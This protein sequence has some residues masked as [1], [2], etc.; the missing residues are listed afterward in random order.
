VLSSKLVL[1]SAS[2]FPALVLPVAEYI[3]AGRARK[4][5]TPRI[6]GNV[7]DPAMPA[8]FTRGHKA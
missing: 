2:W 1:V 6:L 8:N 7:G 4:V 3:A 5:A